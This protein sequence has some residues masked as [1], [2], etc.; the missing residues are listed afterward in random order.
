MWFSFC[1]CKLG[2]ACQLSV[3]AICWCQLQKL[4][5]FLVWVLCSVWKIESYTVHWGAGVLNRLLPC[6]FS[7][8]TLGRM[9]CSSAPN[10]ANFKEGNVPSAPKSLLFKASVLFMSAAGHCC[11]LSLGSCHLPP[12]LAGWESSSTEEQTRRWIW[13]AQCLQMIFFDEIEKNL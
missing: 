3:D 10:I 11:P 12:P 5:R 8:E 7:A 13:A 6:I 9:L 2:E 4:R 1:L